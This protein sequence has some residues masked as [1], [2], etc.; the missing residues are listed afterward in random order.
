MSDERNAAL[1]ALL[2]KV[3][4]SF[5]SFLP[6]GGANAIAD[7]DSETIPATTQATT[8]ATTAPTTMAHSE[9]RLMAHSNAADVYTRRS[10]DTFGALECAIECRSAPLS[11]GRLVSNH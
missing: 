1:A 4:M 2:P 6:H 3:D 5:M 9:R 11:V 7:D 8:A 10:N